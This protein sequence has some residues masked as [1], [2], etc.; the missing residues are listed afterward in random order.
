MSNNLREHIY[1]NL[2]L[3]TTDELVQ[4]WQSNDRKAWEDITFELIREILLERL[5]EVPSQNGPSYENGGDEED[6]G[7]FVEG[8]QDEELEDD[9]NEPVFYDPQHVK[10]LETWLN[11][12]AVV[13]VVVAVILSLYSLPGFHDYI[14]STFPGNRVWNIVAWPFALVISVSERGVQSAF[15]FLILKALASILKILMAMEINSRQVVVTQEGPVIKP[16]QTLG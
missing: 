1:N 4:I 16:A 8:E 13:I 9:D 10:W 15:T 5:G 2:N 14:A 6:K 3:K 12:F 7:E 11:R